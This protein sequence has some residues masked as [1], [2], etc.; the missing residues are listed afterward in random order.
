MNQNPLL[1]DCQKGNQKER[2]RVKKNPPQAKTL[3]DIQSLYPLS[4][5]T[6]RQATKDIQEDVKLLARMLKARKKLVER[7]EITRV[8][9]MGYMKNHDTLLHGDTVLATWKGQT[10]SVLDID[11][12]KVDHPTLYGQYK[13]ELISRVFRLKD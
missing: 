10:R 9:I 12:L 8:R 1:S 5:A 2:G 4:Q 3:Q 7:E 11:R 6:G 13:K